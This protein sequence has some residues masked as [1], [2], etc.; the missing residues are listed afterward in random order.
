MSLTRGSY[1]TDTQ[2]FSPGHR[3][4]SCM[5]SVFARLKNCSRLSLWPV[6][7]NIGE[8]LLGLLGFAASWTFVGPVGAGGLVDFGSSPR[9]TPQ[10]HPTHSKPLQ[11]HPNFPHFHLIR[12]NSPDFFAN[13]NYLTIFQAPQAP[14]T[15]RNQPRFCSF[16]GPFGADHRTFFPGK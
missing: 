14:Q 12:E 5:R 9:P 4:R 16:R 15:A 11:I 3:H 8:L 1:W 2:W 13:S 10:S 6:C 7:E